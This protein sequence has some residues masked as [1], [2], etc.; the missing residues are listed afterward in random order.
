MPTVGGAI[1]STGLNHKQI[2]EV[3]GVL[4]AYKTKVG[5]GDFPSLCDEENGAILASIGKE[6]GA[7]TGRP[8]KCGWLD[9]DEVNQAINMNGVDHLCLI[10]SDVFCNIQN[11]FV[12]HKKELESISKISSVSIEDDAFVDLLNV[13][14]IKTGV[15]T[16]SFTTGPKRG[17][18]VWSN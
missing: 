13:I 17:E 4:K 6:Y 2:D 8:R 5:S 14:K 12:Y 9:F 10:K 16:V 1:N 11:P 18:I 3:I 15:D 7:T